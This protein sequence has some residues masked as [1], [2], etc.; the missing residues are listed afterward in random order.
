MCVGL[1]EVSSWRPKTCFPQQYTYMVR[2]VVG[3]VDVFGLHETFKFD[4]EQAG[5]PFRRAS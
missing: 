3:G 5:P 1:R 4:V 2:A